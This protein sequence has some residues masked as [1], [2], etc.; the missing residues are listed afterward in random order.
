M[1]NIVDDADDGGVHG[2]KRLGESVRSLASA[3]ERDVVAGSGMH[4]IAGNLEPPGGHASRGDGLYHEQLHARHA[5]DLLARHTS[6]N[7]AT[8]IHRPGAYLNRAATA[9]SDRFLGAARNRAEA[10]RP[11]ADWRPFRRRFHPGTQ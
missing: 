8:E 1:L 4:H 6:A 5:S 2:D 10:W 11:P 9:T 7:Y 3:N